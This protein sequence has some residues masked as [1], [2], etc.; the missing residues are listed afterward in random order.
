MALEGGV[1]RWERGLGA[2]IVAPV[3]D[4]RFDGEVGDYG[5]EVGSGAVVQLRGEVEVFAELNGE[6]FEGLARGYD[7]RV[8]H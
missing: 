6:A 2:G 1:I 4:R 8:G 3:E 5:G 7:D